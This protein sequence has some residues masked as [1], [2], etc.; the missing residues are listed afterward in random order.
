MAW[1]G[2]AVMSRGA[3]TERSKERD[4]KVLTETILMVVVVSETEFPKQARLS[5]NS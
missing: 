4:G 2:L 3:E 5:R 1:E